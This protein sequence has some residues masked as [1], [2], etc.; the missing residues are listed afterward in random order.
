MG[1]TMD[2]LYFPQDVDD[3]VVA[4]GVIE[5]DFAEQGFTHAAVGR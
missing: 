3:V 5:I 2:I 4:E 1:W